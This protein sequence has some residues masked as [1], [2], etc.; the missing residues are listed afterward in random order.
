MKALGL[1]WV[2]VA[3]GFVF[4]G[5]AKDMTVDDW[6]RAKVSEEV[7]KIEEISGFYQGRALRE[8]SAEEL[9]GIEMTL[10][11]DTRVAER[12]DRPGAEKQAVL[13]GKIAVFVQ[14][15][16]LLLNFEDGSYDSEDGSFSAQVVISDSSGA[17]TTI[18]FTGTAKEGRVSGRMEV[19]GL[20][21]SVIE[22]ALGR[23][24]PEESQ[25]GAAESPGGSSAKD[26]GE[27]EGDR[28]LKYVGQA[29]WY[30]QGDVSATEV[31]ILK[32][33][34]SSDQEFLDWLNP[35]RAV[36]VSLKVNF[37]TVARPR[38]TS[39][40][41]QNA[42]WDARLGVLRGRFEGGGMGVERYLLSL[43]CEVSEA[44]L[45]CDYLSSIQGQLFRLEARLDPSRF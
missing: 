4:G 12:R 43:D 44:E 20:S 3:M 39:V 23:A 38:V 14:A 2:F 6:R 27:T 41:F 36:D 33:A 10:E 7:Q 21:G 16:P 40:F 19:I 32:R 26:S 8:S 42:Q 29:Q 37:G 25:L 45:A 24:R 34:L 11:S 30:A 9:G 31:L 18:K 5:C 15:Q 13:R 35:V 1:G 17:P 22:Y 28:V